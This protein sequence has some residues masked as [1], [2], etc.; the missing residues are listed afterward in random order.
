MY[1][2]LGKPGENPGGIRPSQV[3]ARGN[4]LMEGIPPGNYELSLQMFGQGAPK[5]QMPKR[6]VNVQNSV[7]TDVMLTLDLT[8]QPKP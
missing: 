2:T 4:F 5:V 6:E 8:T 7:V 1:V 3:D